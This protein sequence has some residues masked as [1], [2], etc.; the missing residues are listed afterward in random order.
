MSQTTFELFCQGAL[1]RHLKTRM[2]HDSKMWEFVIFL[3][4]D[5]KITIAPVISIGVSPMNKIQQV[6]DKV[7]PEM[8]LIAA[9]SWSARAAEDETMEE[10]SKKWV[11]RMSE[12][13]N[14]VERLTCVGKTKNG[15]ETFTRL[16]DIIRDKD[17]KITDFVQFLDDN[18]KLESTKLT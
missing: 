17:G 3:F 18:L 4:K 16:Y 1:K 6:I 15:Q 2:K 5:N 7:S 8:Y 10:L 14:R 9:D 12:H 13:P 11:G